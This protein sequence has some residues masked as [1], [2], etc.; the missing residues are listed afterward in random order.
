MT[1]TAISPRLAIKILWSTDANVGAMAAAGDIWSTIEWPSGWTVRFVEETGS[2]NADLLA[3]VEAGEAGDRFVLAAGHQSAGRGRLDRR[4]DAPRGTNLLAS[5]VFAPVPPHPTELTHRVGLA[6]IAA[7]RLLRP[8]ASFGLKWP[9]DVLM[10]DA[11]LAGVLAQRSTGLD[12]AVVGV[13][14]NVEWAPDD[15]A[16]LDRSHPATLLAMLL[17]ALDA[18]PFDIGPRYRDE[19]STIGR[20][21]RVMLPGGASF[22]GL[23]VDVDGSGQ[24]VV[25]GAD[26]R[27]RAFDAG[28]VVHLR[29]VT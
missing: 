15:G 27:R 6:T 24:L 12:A 16:K 26:R 18:Q 13:G 17:A 5:I 22:E 7:A 8:D 9:N 2:T 10:N 23:A 28:D 29:P 21:V 20:H 4:W 14:V 25:E 3:A 1:R 19:L 11:K